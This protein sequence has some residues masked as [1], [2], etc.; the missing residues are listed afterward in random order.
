MGNTAVQLAESA[1]AQRPPTELDGWVHPC[2]R[3]NG[4]PERAKSTLEIEASDGTRKDSQTSGEPCLH[5]PLHP[6]HSHAGPTP[7]WWNVL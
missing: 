6:I 2:T 3:L 7:S 5:A 4:L 1:A